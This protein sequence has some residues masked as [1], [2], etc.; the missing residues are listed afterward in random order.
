ME[1]LDETEKLFIP[2]PCGFQLCLFCYGKIKEQESGEPGAR[3]CPG[4]RKEFGEPAYKERPG[5]EIKRRDS[6]Q[7]ES[8]PESK[9]AV[10]P[11][12]PPPRQSGGGK[13]GG[14]RRA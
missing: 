1:D 5:K 14:K 6:K 11:K 13:Q 3:L 2:C 9:P 12:A 8:K 4:C 7:T 10:K